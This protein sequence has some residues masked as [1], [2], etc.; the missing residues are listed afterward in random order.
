MA[1]LIYAGDG[2]LFKEC[3]RCHEIKAARYF[4]RNARNPSGLNPPCR[5]CV[6]VR[7]DQRYAEHKDK[8]LEANQRWIVA[9]P[10]KVA[11]R[12]RRWRANNPSYDVEWRLRNL[13]VNRERARIRARRRRAASAEIRVSN[14]ISCA[15]RDQ[16]TGKVKNGRKAFDLLGFTFDDLKAHLERQFKPGMSWSNYGLGG[17]EIDH[18]V[19]ISAHNFSSPDD[20]DFKRCWALSN[21]QPLWASE[22]RSKQ[23]RLDHP[24]QPSLLLQARAS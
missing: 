2:G 7:Q 10:E 3:S 22:N 6:K 15:I 5:A 17:W 18:K 14:A 16:I 4:C 11:E 12:R 13:E 21:L 23:G 20:I 8:V 1:T 24:F 19:P 9:N